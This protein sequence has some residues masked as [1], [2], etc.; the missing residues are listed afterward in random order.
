LAPFW[1]HGSL[2]HIPVS[3]DE[4]V[5]LRRRILVATTFFGAAFDAGDAA[6]LASF[7]SEVLGRCVDEGASPENAVISATCPEL[8][9]RLAFHRVPEEKVAKNRFHPDLIT[10]D[11][12]TELERLRRLGASVLNEVHKGTSR[13]TTLAD[14][15]GNEFDLIAG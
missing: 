15:E 1:S 10:T 12:D 2:G 3:Y 13:W 8:G 4:I 7:W 5:G 9:P 11:Y 14:P 6:R